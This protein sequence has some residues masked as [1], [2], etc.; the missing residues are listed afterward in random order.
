MG[1][2]CLRSRGLATSN[3]KGSGGQDGCVARPHNDDIRGVALGA[4]V[5]T[6]LPQGGCAYRRVRTGPRGHAR[7]GPLLHLASYSSA[8]PVLHCADIVA[9]RPSSRACAH[10]RKRRRTACVCVWLCASAREPTSA[11][12]QIGGF[13][14]NSADFDQLWQTSAEF[15]RCRPNVAGFGQ[16]SAGFDPTWQNSAILGR[17]WRNLR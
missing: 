15:D 9:E 8:P 14:P 2:T 16:M 17:F 13:R 5:G 12:S 10:D 3:H 7:G 6:A 11:R 4:W 1:K